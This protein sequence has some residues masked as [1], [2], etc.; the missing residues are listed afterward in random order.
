M[1]PPPP[2]KALPCPRSAPERAPEAVRPESGPSLARPRRSVG[3]GARDLIRAV[4]RPG[5]PRSAP[6]PR[7]CTSSPA[8]SRSGSAAAA[9][10][11]P[12]SS[13][14]SST[15]ASTRPASS[16]SPCAR[17]GRS[18]TSA[19]PASGTRRLHHHVARRRPAPARSDPASRDSGRVAGPWRR[20]TQPRRA[21]RAPIGPGVPSPRSVLCQFRLGGEWNAAHRI[22]AWIGV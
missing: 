9:G 20:D 8:R 22:E 18:S 17:R 2:K 21:A 16:P 15:S 7:M 3:S 13:A 12:F 4:R 14:S 19:P 10:A 5:P 6:R 11:T 1:P